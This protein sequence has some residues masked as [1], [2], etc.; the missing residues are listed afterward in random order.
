MKKNPVKIRRLPSGR[1]RVR[2]GRRI[3]ARS[4]TRAK[5]AR[6]ANLL[7]AVTHGFRP[8]TRQ[9]KLAQGW[10]PE[11]SV[12]YG[13]PAQYGPEAK[14]MIANRRRLFGLPNPTVKR[15]K[16]R[17]RM[18]GKSETL[19]FRQKCDKWTVIRGSV[20]TGRFQVVKRGMST[21]ALTAWAKANK[22][23]T[24]TA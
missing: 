12:G 5:A 13:R 3:T 20:K 7:R 16:S 23:K 10:V 6:Q 19:A 17:K 11:D 4:T 2:S 14:R 8:L 9:K 21:P 18:P 22:F 1:F 24:T 15:S